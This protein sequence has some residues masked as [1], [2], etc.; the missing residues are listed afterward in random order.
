MGRWV[1]ASQ[2]QQDPVPEGGSIF[3]KQWFN[4][5]FVVDTV[6]PFKGHP[7]GKKVRFVI[8]SWDTAVKAKQS[9]DYW[10]CTTWALVVG[11]EH[12]YMLDYYMERMEYTEGRTK[13][14]D[15][16]ARWSPHAILIEDSNS[17][18]SI[19]SDLRT[20][21]IPMIAI[22]PAGPDKQANARAVSPMFEAGMI[23]L[24]EGAEWADQYVENMCRFPKGEHDDDIDST[25][26]ALN[27][28]RRR[29]HG[30]MEYIEQEMAKEQE[31]D[32]CSYKGCAHGEEGKRRKITVNMTIIR[33]GDLRYCSKDCMIAN[34]GK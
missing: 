18:S 17:G 2:Y 31:R 5:R 13:V 16:N 15:T 4:N 10:A 7:F 20:T 14:Q 24:P 8:Q 30:V 1:Y 11:E 33:I 28:L 26:Q 12:I 32:L 22:S 9:N 23:V 34:T 19:L 25:S 6:A 29:Q 3:Q 27:Y 21:G